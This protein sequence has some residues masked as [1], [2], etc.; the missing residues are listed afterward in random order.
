MPAKTD[1]AE[2]DHVDRFLE[3]VKRELPEIDLAVEGIVDRLS[4]L[5]WRLKRMLDETLEELEGLDLSS[6]EWKV[7]TALRLAG[8]PYRR[9]PGQLAKRAELSSAAMTNRLDRMQGAGF[10]RRLPDPNDRRGIQVELTDEGR[11][12]WERAAAAQAAK[13]ALVASALT[14]REQEELNTLLRRL[15]IAFERLEAGKKK[16]VD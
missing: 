6:G 9:S 12:A 7:L 13:E 3:T 2:Q 8:P 10:V 16:G 1:P 14:R 4:G 15:M 11:L 5:N